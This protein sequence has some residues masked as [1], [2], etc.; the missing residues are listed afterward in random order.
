MKKEPKIWR[1]RDGVTY[2]NTIHDKK[3]YLAQ[4]YP[5]LWEALVNAGIAF[6]VSLTANIIL[7]WIRLH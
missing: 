5:N 4:Y 6:I 1:L 3:R 2:Y 7:L